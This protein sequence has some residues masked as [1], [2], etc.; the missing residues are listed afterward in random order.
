VTELLERAL[1]EL[2]KLPPPEQDEAAK[3]LLAELE[4]EGR[5]RNSLST[6]LWTLDALAD[7]ALAE[8]EA[9]LT[10]PLDPAKL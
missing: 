2:S 1:T 7:E 5:W 8:H 6:S 9:G 3:W 4:D 10:W